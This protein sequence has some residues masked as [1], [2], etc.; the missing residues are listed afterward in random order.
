LREQGAAASM[1]A[2]MGKRLITNMEKRDHLVLNTAGVM[3]GD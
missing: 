3:S 2:Q 1:E